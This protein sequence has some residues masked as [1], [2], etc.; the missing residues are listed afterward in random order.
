MTKF[1]ETIDDLLNCDAD[2]GSSSLDGGVEVF[3][4]FDN[5]FLSSIDW[6]VVGLIKGKS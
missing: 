1:G 4:I 5:Y 3:D 2:M 6:S